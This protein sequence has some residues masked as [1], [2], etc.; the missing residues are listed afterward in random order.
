MGRGR[1]VRAF[2][3]KGDIGPRVDEDGEWPEARNVSFS[4][5][6]FS[7]G[8]SGRLI[9]ISV[10]LEILGLCSFCLVLFFFFSRSFFVLLSG[11][12]QLTS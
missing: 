9:V 4:A 12:Y 5:T 7:Q 6:I 8:V 11:I 3:R 1:D 2:L 10:A